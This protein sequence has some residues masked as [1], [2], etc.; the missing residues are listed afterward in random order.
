MDF[1]LKEWFTGLGQWF[2]KHGQ[3]SVRS[4]SFTITIL[5]ITNELFLWSLSPIN[6]PRY[7]CCLICERKAISVAMSPH[8]HR[9]V[10]FCYELVCGYWMRWKYQMTISS[11]WLLQIVLSKG[12]QNKKVLMS[13]YDRYNRKG[14]IGQRIEMLPVFHPKKVHN[15]KYTWR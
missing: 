2:Y 12:A 10:I 13:F 3:C 15:Y 5:N 1:F 7:E 4:N 8:P 11:Q 6:T 9:Y 14:I